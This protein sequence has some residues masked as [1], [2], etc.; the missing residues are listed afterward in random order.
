MMAEIMMRVCDRT[1]GYRIGDK[2]FLYRDLMKTN[3]HMTSKHREFTTTGVV[4]RINDRWF[5]GDGDQ[6]VKNRQIVA[7][8]IKSVLAR[9]HN[10]APAEIRTSHRRIALCSTGG[11][12]LIDDAVVI[13]DNVVGGLR[14]TAPL[15][16][17]LPRLIERLGRAAEAAPDDAMLDAATISRLQEWHW[18]LSPRRADI[19]QLADPG[20]DHLLIFAPGSRVSVRGKGGSAERTV[21]EAEFVSVGEARVLMYRCE[22]P[23]GAK[24]WVAH[25]QVDPL[26]ND[27]RRVLWNPSSNE[28]TELAA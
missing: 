2:P 16:D 10:I 28:L 14:L 13:F 5:R 7:D 24:A 20:D 3:R 27:W 23:N 1:V 9:E 11:A 17:D 6:A 26:G 15:F 18:N 8:A 12:T 19:V 21:L 25:D 22:A 4:I